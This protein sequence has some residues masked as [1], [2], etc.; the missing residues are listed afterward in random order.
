MPTLLVKNA[1]LPVTMDDER[2]RLAGGGLY[3][4]DNVIRQ[5][6]TSDNL[7]ASADRIIDAAGMI[8]LPGLVN[9]H[10]HFYQRD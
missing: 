2:R 6:D 3:V 7:P 10:H 5:V 8:V 1:T 9:C 4:E